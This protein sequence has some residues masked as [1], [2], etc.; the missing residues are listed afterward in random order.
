MTCG[1]K[2]GE[3]DC[4]TVSQVDSLGLSAILPQE[5]VD[6]VLT[7][8]PYNIGKDYGDSVDDCKVADIWEKFKFDW[9]QLV[10]LVAKEKT[11]ISFTCSQKQ[12]WEYRPLFEAQG[13]VFR[14]VAVWHNP[15]RKAGSYPGMWP[16]SWEPIMDFT[17]GGFRKLNNSNGVGGMDVWIEVPPTGIKH[18]ARRPVFC[19]EN[20]V[21]LLSNPNEI[22]FDPFAG[23]GTTLVAAKKL[24][25]HF[26]GFDIEPKYVEIARQRL[27]EIPFSSELK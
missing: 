15:Q 16:F 11:H 22:V 12:I 1:R 14:H 23:S 10:S 26:L 18:P 8:P 13:C 3:F 25:R 5:S 7:D 2:V 19:W 6:F 17:K 27:E 9:V 21:G 24:G 20:L 4:C